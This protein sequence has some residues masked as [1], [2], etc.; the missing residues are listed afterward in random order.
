MKRVVFLLIIISLTSC[1]IPYIFPAPSEHRQ[2]IDCVRSQ[3]A[4]G[5][6][7]RE[8]VISIL[9][10]PDVTRDRF[11][12]YERKEYDGGIYYGLITWSG[13]EVFGQVFMS[14]YFEFDNYGVLTD[15]R[16]HKF[17]KSGRL[18]KDDEDTSKMEEACDQGKESC[19]QNAFIK[20]TIYEEVTTEKLQCVHK[21]VLCVQECSER[22]ENNPGTEASDKAACNFN[23]DYSLN[24]CFESL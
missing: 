11:I 22:F 3:I 5:L 16:T 9:G 21:V 2:E 10:Q 15:F 19:Y 4:V 18:I 13:P 14:L 8:D 12:I 24:V 17:D 7:T 23:C 20:E 6:T 1:T